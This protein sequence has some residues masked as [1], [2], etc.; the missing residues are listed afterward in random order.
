VPGGPADLFDVERAQA[1]LHV[2]HALPRGRLLAQQVGLEGLHPGDDEQQRGVFGDQAGR[3]QDRVILLLE[4]GQ[5][6][7]D[8]LCRLH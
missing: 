5:E 1:L 3:R 7:A 4:V 8:D 2:G 6:T